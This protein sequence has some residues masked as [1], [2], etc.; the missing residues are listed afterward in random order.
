MHFFE[1]ELKNA[2]ITFLELHDESI[3]KINIVVLL[4]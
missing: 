2:E 3:K 4:I 1:L